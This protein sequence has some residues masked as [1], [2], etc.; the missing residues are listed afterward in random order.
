MCVFLPNPFYIDEL[1]DLTGLDQQV[2]D[3]VFQW[4]QTKQF[5]KKLIEMIRF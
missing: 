5:E 1:Q 2:Y 4:K 3:Y